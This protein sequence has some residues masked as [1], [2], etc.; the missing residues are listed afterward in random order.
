M[1][2]RANAGAV[3]RTWQLRV[4]IGGSRGTPLATC[5]ADQCGC[6]AS[7]R[8][9][10]NSPCFERDSYWCPAWPRGH[11]LFSNRNCH[12]HEIECDGVRFEELVADNAADMHA[13]H[14]FQ[15]DGKRSIRAL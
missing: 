12:P 5:R 10:V 13:E 4:S 8:L 2:G 15:S 1:P 7:P 14:V 11:S 3:M 9:R 6:Y